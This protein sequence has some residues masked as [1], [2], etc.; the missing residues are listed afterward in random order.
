[1]EGVQSM[2]D[3]FGELGKLMSESN[4][5]DADRQLMME[6]IT[7][8]ESLFAAGDELAER[9]AARPSSG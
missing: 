7:L 9:L 2:L 3:R 1:M 8:Y 4:S 5:E 6:W